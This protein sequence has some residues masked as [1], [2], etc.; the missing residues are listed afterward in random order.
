MFSGQ[1]HVGGAVGGISLQKL[2]VCS[3]GAW[4]G[5]E[6]RWVSRELGELGQGRRATQGAAHA[7]TSQTGARSACTGA[8]S[9]RAHGTPSSWPPTYQALNALLD[10]LGLRQEARSQLARH[11]PNQLVVPQLLAA[12]RGGRIGRRGQANWEEGAG[13]TWC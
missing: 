2:A 8:V 11:L 12:L 4:G 13:G 9:L 7:T 3:H 5:R 6:A 1:I 10:D